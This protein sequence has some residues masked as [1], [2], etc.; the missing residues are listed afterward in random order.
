VSPTLGAS[1][2]PA[3]TIPDPQPKATDE[4]AEL[5]EDLREG[6]AL[7]TQWA[8]GYEHLTALAG[9]L[10]GLFL[11]VLALSDGA[12]VRVLAGILAALALTLTIV[13]AAAFALARRGGAP[14]DLRAPAASFSSI[15]ARARATLG[16]FAL[17]ATALAALIT[18]GVA[19]ATGKADEAPIDVRPALAAVPEAPTAR[20][21]VPPEKRADFTLKREG[22]A[23]A[24]GG[25]LYVPPS[26]RS[27]DGAFDLIAHFHGNVQLV[28][29]SVEAAKVNALVYVVNA[30]TGSGPY[31]ERYAQPAIFDDALARIR[32][33][34]EK[35]G[36]KNAKMRRLALSSWSAGYGAITKILEAKK[37]QERV[38]AIL[39]L[40]GLHV[41]Y[42]DPKVKGKLD[43]ARLAPFVR[44]V[45]EAAE[46][47]K[48][49]S[50]THSD[51]ETYGYASTQEV[52]DVLLREVGRDR[53]PKAGTPPRVT[54]AAA[55]GAVP[56]STEKW[57][58]Q[59][60]EGRVEGMIVRGYTGRS[61]EHHMAHL[62]QMSVTVLPD[63]VERWK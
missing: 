59:S 4:I 39:M 2:P 63:L 52:A 62:I 16:A 9:V 36:L 1:A 34:A 48:L 23:P 45:K 42:M 25:V 53:A 41:A 14:R 37:N 35:R 60:S 29:E 54:L 11:V 44:F 8:L 46:G 26:F 13:A 6:A 5:A 19:T 20:P 32:D 30:G 10:A 49:F 55:A 7:R 31:E 51:T 28:E 61:P 15:S 18:V 40:D 24:A 22:H 17:S 47:R 58:E 50:I 38:D 43:M 33:A 12:A 57:L 21:D 27:D 3:S 56:K